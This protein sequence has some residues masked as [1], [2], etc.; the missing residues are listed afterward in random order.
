MLTDRSQEIETW[1]GRGALS[2]TTQLRGGDGVRGNPKGPSL[3]PPILSPQKGGGALLHSVKAK[4]QP[5]V[6]NMYRSVRL[7]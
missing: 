6:K 5:A 2:C 4:T 1:R 3:S 7:H